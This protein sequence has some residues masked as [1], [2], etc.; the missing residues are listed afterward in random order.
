VVLADDEHLGLSVTYRN[1]DPLGHLI[2]AARESA[3]VSVDVMVG[4]IPVMLRGGHLQLLHQLA[5]A[6]VGSDGP[7]WPG[8]AITVVTSSEVDASL[9]PEVM[10]SRPD[11]TVVVHEGHRTALNTGPDGPL[12]ILDSEQACAV[13]WIRDVDTLP[14]WELA[15]PLRTAVSWWASVHGAALVH[16]GAVAGPLGAVLLVGAGG[17]G[18]STSTMACLDRGLDVLGD[19]FCL[20]EPPSGGDC[21]SVVH[22]IHR[23]AKLSSTSLELLPHLGDRLAGWGCGD[24]QLVDLGVTRMQPKPVRALCHVVHGGT[25]ATHLE[26]IS[27]VQGLRAVAPSTMVQHYPWERQFWQVLGDTVRSVSCYRLVVGSPAEV[28]GVLAGLLHDGIV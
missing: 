6:L 27:R 15:S 16:T 11:E 1:P 8:L 28:P 7:L 13:M 24:K 20:V 4:P 18:K 10:F 14:V 5:A 25:A 19:D 26:P 9:I 22:G 3:T 23:L 21:D 12:W 17:A 2:D